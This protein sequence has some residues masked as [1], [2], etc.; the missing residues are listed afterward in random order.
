LG[1]IQSPSLEPTHADARRRTA[2]GL[3]AEA[4]SVAYQGCQI[5]KKPFDGVATRQ[6]PFKKESLV[7]TIYKCSNGKKDKI[8]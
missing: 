4:R 1:K 2:S 8:K 7:S 5:A 3:F 6:N